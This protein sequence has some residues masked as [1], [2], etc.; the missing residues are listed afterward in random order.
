MAAAVWGWPWRKSNSSSEPNRPQQWR[1]D[2]PG[3][4]QEPANH[5]R[6][7]TTPPHSPLVEVSSKSDTGVL[8]VMGKHNTPHICSNINGE[9]YTLALGTTK[10]HRHMTPD[11]PKPEPPD[12][13]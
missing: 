9:E 6:L 5:Y 1:E 4:I 2:R 3:A 10:T 12:T 7:T 8:D 11:R 13:R